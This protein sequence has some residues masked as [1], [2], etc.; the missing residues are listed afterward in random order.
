MSLPG[1]YNDNTGRAYPLVPFSNALLGVMVPPIP[2]Q[3]GDWAAN[4]LVITPGKWVQVVGSGGRGGGFWQS[5][6]PSSGGLG[7]V[8]WTF[9][10]LPGRQY[11]VSATWPASP[12][13]ASNARFTVVETEG[14]GYF[15][16]L[17]VRIDQRV[18]PVQEIAYGS[19]WL[20]L[21]IV[22]PTRRTLLVSVYDDSDAPA[23]ADAILIEDVTPPDTTVPVEITPPLDTL[24]DFGCLV[25]LDAE[26][27]SSAHVVYLHEIRR[28]GTTFTFDFRS[29][30]PGL[31]GHALVFSR[32]LTDSEY[33][34]DYVEAVP[35]D[36]SGEPIP[37]PS[38]SQDVLWEGF[39]VTGALDS[40]AALMPVDG[41][42][43]ATTG[44]QVEPA[45]VQNLGRGYVRTIN[46]ANQDRTHVSPPPGCQSTDGPDAYGYIVNARGL[47]GDVRFVEGYNVAIRQNARNNSL[48]FVSIQGAGDGVPCAEVPL[49]P[50]ETSPDG[51]TLLSGGPSCDE[52]INSINGLT[53]S[54]IQLVA[55]LGTTIVPAPPD[56]PNTLIVNFDRNNMTVCGTT[57]V[58]VEDLG[59]V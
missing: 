12:D 51:G 11:R 15:D 40:L 43:E 42:L 31:L 4:G 16:L 57:E 50:G 22:T 47:V 30:A 24:I 58:V 13:L 48:T 56:Q 53:S 34:T 59:D 8:T 5:T 21:G 6:S 10:A 49:Y 32:A 37:G 33:A 3:I 9:V 35:L 18:D 55:D 14:Q 39:L 46:L 44:P 52:V 38:G 25:G 29:D 36:A 17:E 20:N 1:F 28:T 27:D 7:S 23:V 54:I 2:T 26:F 45:L 41:P 19:G